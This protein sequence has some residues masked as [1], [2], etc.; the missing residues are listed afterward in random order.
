MKYGEIPTKRVRSR[1]TVNERPDD[2]ELLWCG[3]KDHLENEYYDNFC[4]ELKKEWG[5]NSQKI[6]K[7]NTRMQK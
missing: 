6:A 2:R 7:R 5:K 3:N 1:N 4:F